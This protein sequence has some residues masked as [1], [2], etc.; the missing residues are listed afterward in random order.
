M[1]YSIDG[2]L[3]AKSVNVYFL[4]SSLQVNWCLGM[5]TVWILLLEKE[6]LKYETIRASWS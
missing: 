3:N 1:K 4:G 5:S 6:I 2:Y